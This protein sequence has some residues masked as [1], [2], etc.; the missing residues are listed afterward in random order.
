M[1]NRTALAKLRKQG[2][3]QV[4]EEQNR[5]A[6]L[7]EIVDQQLELVTLSLYVATQGQTSFRGESLECHLGELKLKTSQHIAMCAGQFRDDNPAV[8]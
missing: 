4:T 8:R 1:S 6:S 5:M 3:K 2:Q 7:R